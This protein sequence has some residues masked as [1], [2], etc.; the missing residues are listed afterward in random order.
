[1]LVSEGENVARGGEC[2]EDNGMNEKVEILL[3]GNYAE[4][5]KAIGAS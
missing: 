3:F 4:Y 2:A 5:T 1:M